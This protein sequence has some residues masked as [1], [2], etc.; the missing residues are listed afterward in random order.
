VSDKTFIVLFKPP[1]LTIQHVVAATA[2][3][4]GEH[5]VLLDSEGKLVALFLLEII[6]SWNEIP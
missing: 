5:L 2:E 6:Q 4:H 1:L 3:I